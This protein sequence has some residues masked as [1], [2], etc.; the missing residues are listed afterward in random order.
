MT[1]LIIVCTEDQG[2]AEQLASIFRKYDE[3]EVETCPNAKKVIDSILEGRI[4]QAFIVARTISYGMDK[5]ELQGATDP[6]VVD[7]GMRLIQK[8]LNMDEITSVPK[9]LKFIAFLDCMGFRELPVSEAMQIVLE[10][11]PDLKTLVKPFETFQLEILLCEALDVVCAIHPDLIRD[12][13][14]EIQ[15]EI[16]DEERRKKALRARP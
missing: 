11:R 13:K 16:N 4:P 2:V 1:K 3:F 12:M 7:S 6:N 9:A 10:R 14:E 8:L 5:Y 15:R